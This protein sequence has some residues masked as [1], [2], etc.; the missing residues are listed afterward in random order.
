MVVPF[1]DPVKGL[2]CNPDSFVGPA[3]DPVGE[4]VGESV[5]DPVEELVEEPVEQLV[6]D[7]KRKNTNAWK[8]N[9]KKLSRNLHN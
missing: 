6:F 9:I 2:V 3:V 5:G 8:R 4:P 1:G 7:T